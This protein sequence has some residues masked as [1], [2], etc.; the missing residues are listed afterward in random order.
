MGELGLALGWLGAED[1]GQQ[2]AERRRTHPLVVI[3]NRIKE[4]EAE[5]ADLELTN[6][7]VSIINADLLRPMKLSKTPMWL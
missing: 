4:A 3:S 1:S 6:T 5:H 2:A 7:S